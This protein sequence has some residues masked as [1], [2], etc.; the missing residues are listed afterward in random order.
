MNVIICPICGEHVQANASHVCAEKNV[1]PTLKQVSQYEL[2]TCRKLNEALRKREKEHLDEI[3]RYKK[4]ID[5]IIEGIMDN[6]LPC[7]PA[8]EEYNCPP[9]LHDAESSHSRCKRCWLQS[10]LGET[11]ES[12]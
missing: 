7:P 9:Y 12:K 11:N 6:P 8:K 2:D 1:P 5:E 4:I 10:I 3:E